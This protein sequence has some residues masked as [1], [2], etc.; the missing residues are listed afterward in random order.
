MEKHHGKR[1]EKYKSL[2]AFANAYAN[3]DQSPLSRRSHVTPL[4]QSGRILLNRH[5][6]TTTILLLE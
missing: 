4:D 3:V 2:R 1:H 6:Y 5:F